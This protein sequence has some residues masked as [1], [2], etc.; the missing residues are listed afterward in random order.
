[1]KLFYLS[2][3]LMAGMV[4]SIR[5]F[6]K[7]RANPC[8]CPTNNLKFSGNCEC[9]PAENACEDCITITAEEDATLDSIGFA[10][11]LFMPTVATMALDGDDT[12][13]PV[14]GPIKV[15]DIERLEKWLCAVL[16]TH[17]IDLSL[18]AVYADGVLTIKHIGCFPLVD[19]VVS[20]G[21]V[22][23]VRCCTLEVVRK[24]ASQVLGEVAELSHGDNTATLENN[25]YEYTGTTATDEATAAELATDLAT[26]MGTLGVTLVGDVV[27]TVNNLSGAFDI[28]Y[29]SAS[30]EPVMIGMNPAQE[31]DKKEMFT[32]PV[33]AE[34]KTK[35]K[36][37]GE[38]EE[39]PVTL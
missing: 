1:M 11:M 17:E 3:M 34:A 12:L 25:P 31:C 39:I 19:P 5:E 33:E 4:T 20:A 15:S 29:Y 10:D 2:I 21:E 6:G 18:S 38:D 28:C 36:T 23:V 37:E 35:K 22:T 30:E 16:A 32:C 26:A 7:K 13:I 24:Y 8:A 27:V 14:Y 9:G